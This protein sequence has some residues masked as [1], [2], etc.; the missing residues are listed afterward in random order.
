M[1]GLLYALFL[2]MGLAQGR[3]L[4]ASGGEG[5]FC[6]CKRNNSFQDKKSKMNVEY[7][8]STGMRVL[9]CTNSSCEHFRNPLAFS[10]C[11]EEKKLD[12]PSFAEPG[13]SVTDIFSSVGKV[14]Q[15]NRTSFAWH[16]VRAVG[17]YIVSNTLLKRYFGT[18][19]EYV[20]TENICLFNNEIAA[21]LIDAW[22][23]ETIRYLRFHYCLRKT[24]DLND[25]WYG[26]SFFNRYTLTA[27]LIEMA[28]VYGQELIVHNVDWIS[29]EWLFALQSR[30]SKQ[31][32][33]RVAYAARSGLRLLI[34]SGMTVMI[35][36]MYG[37]VCPYR[38]ASVFAFTPGGLQ[39]AQDKLG[40]PIPEG[41]ILV[42]IVRNLFFTEKVETS[43]TD[44]PQQ[45][46]TVE[47]RVKKYAAV[48]RGERA[49]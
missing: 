6:F 47:S 32:Y 8:K 45:S 25:R 12:E 33:A 19:L 21:Q 39:Y 9:R 13:V 16:A 15:S 10:G 11:S 37:I 23:F 28:L 34:R 27:G 20:T 29:Q 4:D 41:H 7:E 14:V 42:H 3:V 17:K 5:W 24:I 22:L 31:Q 48:L 1:K 40:A 18:R 46:T 44:S 26:E 35:Y 43:W 2:L 38:I 30:L 36:C 49:D